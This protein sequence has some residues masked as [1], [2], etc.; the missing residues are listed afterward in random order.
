MAA[1]AA[2]SA[3]HPR[4]TP[5]PPAATRRGRGR[6]RRRF[7]GWQR[8]R[9]RDTALPPGPSAQPSLD[10]EACAPPATSTRAVPHST[11][12]P[13]PAAGNCSATPKPCKPGGEAPWGPRGP[14]ALRP[15]AEM[16]PELAGIAKPQRLLHPAVQRCS[17][18][19][20][21]MET[22]KPLFLRKPSLQS[23][24]SAGFWGWQGASV[25]PTA[26][27]PHEVPR[28]RARSHCISAWQ[29]IRLGAHK[30]I[31]CLAFF[32]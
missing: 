1:P 29:S 9:P 32:I 5:A 10:L 19:L 12:S 6:G 18:H 27:Q 11:L 28:R 14:S 26:P 24:L 16:V 15:G 21:V 22:L 23:Q 17:G 30:A 8:L 4:A 7:P 2:G 13:F 31:S 20:W 3:P 25:V